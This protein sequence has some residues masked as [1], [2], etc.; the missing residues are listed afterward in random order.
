MTSQTKNK[1]VHKKYLKTVLALK[2]EIT[3]YTPIALQENSRFLIQ[4]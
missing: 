3:Y 1:L 2:L 4:P